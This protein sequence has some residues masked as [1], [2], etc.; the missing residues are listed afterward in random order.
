MSPKSSIPPPLLN[1]GI[2]GRHHSRSS[3]LP[4]PRRYQRTGSTLPT[5]SRPKLEASEGD[6]S[7][8]CYDKSSIPPPLLNIGI[9]DRHHSRSY[10]LP[11]PRRYQRTGSTLPTTSRPK[12]EASQGVM[13]HTCYDK[14]SIPP[15]SPNILS[16]FASMEVSMNGFHASND[17]TTE[18]CGLEGSHVNQTPTCHP[19]ATTMRR[20]RHHRPT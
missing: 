12:P 8:T 13:S 9:K 6:M 3:P 18:A 20:S 7:P 4:R 11:R 14:S 2:K 19:N 1:I 15:P 5:T 16:P 17:F 10:P